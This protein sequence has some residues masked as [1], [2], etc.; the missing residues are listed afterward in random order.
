MISMDTA[1]QRMNEVVSRL[2]EELTK[3]RTGRANASLVDGIMVESYGSKM[4]LKQVAS[5]TIPEATQ[6]MITPWDKSLLGA[7]EGAIRTADLGMNPVND[8]AG[9][10]LNLPPLSAERRGQMIKLVHSV[11]EEA[12]VAM[13]QVRHEAMETVK[14]DEKAGNATED[15]RFRTEKQLNDMIADMNKKIDDRVTTKEQEL[16]TV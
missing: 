5:I 11:A 14:Q 3:L 2:D 12:R 4:P 9:I 15:D 16:N 1:K 8:G 6:I 7:I 13:R 10:R